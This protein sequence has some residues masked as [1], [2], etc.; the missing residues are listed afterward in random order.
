M[1]PKVVGSIPI[2]VRQIFQLTPWGYKIRVTRRRRWWTQSD[3]TTYFLTTFLRPFQSHVRHQNKSI[4]SNVT[5]YMPMPWQLTT[6]LL[7]MDIAQANCKGSCVLVTW[8]PVPVLIVHFSAFTGR[9]IPFENF[10]IGTTIDIFVNIKVIY[11]SMVKIKCK[12]AR[13]F[14]A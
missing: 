14:F 12:S 2:V 6:W 5:I 9:S 3:I 4:I 1:G 8:Q 7:W 11:I 13:N 10:T